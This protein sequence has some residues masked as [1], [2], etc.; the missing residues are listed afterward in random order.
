MIS[1]SGIETTKTIQTSDGKQHLV[2]YSLKDYEVK[3]LPKLFFF[4]FGRVLQMDDAFG[5]HPRAC[6][7]RRERRMKTRIFINV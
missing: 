6:K 4:F 5:Q 2:V 1:D 7:V 3:T